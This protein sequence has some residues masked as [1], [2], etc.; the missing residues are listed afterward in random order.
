MKRLD[1]D[2]RAAE[3]VVDDSPVR[4]ACGERRIDDRRLDRSDRELDVGHGDALEREASVVVGRRRAA[5]LL[6][7][8]VELAG[9]AVADEL[10][11]LGETITSIKKTGA[12]PMD[13]V[14][15]GGSGSSEAEI[16]EAVRNG[17]IK[18]NIDTDTQWGFWDGI[19][20]YEA[21]NR[22]YL[23]AQIGNPEGDDKPN[24][25]YYDPREC[26]R[27][28]EVN[29]VA[30]L[31]DAFADLKCQNILG[32]GQVEPAQNVLGPRRGGLPV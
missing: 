26:M 7:R 18:M 24:K 11:E 1:L 9:V 15:H 28:A 10:L 21:K 19:R 14:F 20:E 27:A 8:R 3:V 2:G 30:R 32:L 13:L 12:K 17:V 6:E 31:G 16:A 29:T 23:Q 22:D 5:A 4:V 25:K